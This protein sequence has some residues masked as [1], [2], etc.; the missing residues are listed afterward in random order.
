MY[1]CNNNRHVHNSVIV[2]SWYYTTT[3]LLFISI[4]PPRKLNPERLYAL[5]WEDGTWCRTKLVSETG[6]TGLTSDGRVHVCYPDFGNDEQVEVNQ[7]RELPKEFY[8]LPF[9]V[10]VACTHVQVQ[11]ASMY[12]CMNIY[13]CNTAF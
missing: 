13:N 3:V 1:V 2:S 11:L 6:Q 10:S 7:L 8:T 9:Q 5:C 4:A 12:M